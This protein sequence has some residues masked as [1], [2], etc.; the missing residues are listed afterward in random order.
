MQYRDVR[1]V[2]DPKIPHD[3][4]VCANDQCVVKVYGVESGKPRYALASQIC[5]LLENGAPT[6]YDFSEPVWDGRN[7][8]PA[9]LPTLEL[10]QEMSVPPD[11][12]ASRLNMWQ[13][14]MQR[15]LVAEIRDE[16]KHAMIN[17]HDMLA[18][19][20]DL[21]VACE[22]QECAPH[23]ENIPDDVMRAAVTRVRETGGVL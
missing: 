4:R 11:F 10:T 17:G 19:R 15:D 3:L 23:Y 20:S 5:T 7:C 1:I 22:L 8:P 16:L 21:Q 14:E 9:L 12:L 6:P 18:S 13:A 2:P